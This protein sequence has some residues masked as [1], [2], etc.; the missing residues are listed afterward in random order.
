[1]LSLFIKITFF[2]IEVNSDKRKL[3]TQTFKKSLEFILE[4]IPHFY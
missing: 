2:I 4:M 1:M 3:C